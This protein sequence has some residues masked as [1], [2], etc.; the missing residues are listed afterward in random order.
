M[1]KKAKV[2]KATAKAAKQ[3]KLPYTEQFQWQYRHLTGSTRVGHKAKWVPEPTIYDNV[4][5]AVTDAIVYSS[6]RAT[7]CGG[8]RL[9]RIISAKQE[10]LSHPFMYVIAQKQ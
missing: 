10:K 5:A 2:A 3:A 8:H 9:M 6:C 1:K 4:N 7:D